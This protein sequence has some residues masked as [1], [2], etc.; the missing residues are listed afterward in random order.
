M[1]IKKLN[2]K[3]INNVRKKQKKNAFVAVFIFLIILMASYR[4][5]LTKVGNSFEEKTDG[6]FK[7]IASYI[8]NKTDKIENK[9]EETIS[10][11]ANNIG[12]QIK[13]VLLPESEV[14]KEDIQT[15]LE[16]EIGDAKIDELGI[17]ENGNLVYMDQN[18]LND[19]FDKLK[20]LGAN[21]IRVEIGWK[22]VQPDSYTDYNW[23][24][25]DRIL[26]TAEKYGVKILAVVNY[27]I[28]AWAQNEP[29]DSDKHIP[30]KNSDSFAQFAGTVAE[31]YKD[32]IKYFEIWNEPNHREFWYDNPNPETYGLL[33]KVSYVKIKE[34]NPEA[35]VISGG[36]AMV[37][38]NE[39][40]SIT[41]YKFISALYE[42]DAH[43]YFDAIALHPYTYPA[44]PVSTDWSEWIQVSRIRN[45]MIAKGEGNKK[46]W[47]TEY[48]APTNGAGEKHEIDEW[49]FSYGNDYM[50]ETAQ[51][52]MAKGLILRYNQSKD[53]MGPVFWYAIQDTAAIDNNP[54]KFFGI[55]R[56]DGTEKPIYR[57]LKR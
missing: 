37:G 19:Y 39:G 38:E 11:K 1:R 16:L 12:G 52:I 20:R 25:I 42:S 35:I 53:W 40:K 17:A 57:T 23:S 2:R 4:F 9:T 34:A 27:N 21:W 13:N 6:N 54:E 49:N 3:K 8:E 50:S 14:P 10:A 5:Y 31:R 29:Y 43:N 51:D 48:G 18:E 24:G 7:E 45:L 41:P 32:R 22:T 47:I 44:S 28:P 30:P 15:A 33:L 55:F 46:I 36:L 56:F 26:E